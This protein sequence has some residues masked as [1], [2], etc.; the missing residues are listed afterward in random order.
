MISYHGIFEAFYSVTLVHSDSDAMLTSVR[1]PL[2]VSGV[3]LADIYR[4][5]SG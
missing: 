3:T 2:Y 1:D 4:Y 5:L